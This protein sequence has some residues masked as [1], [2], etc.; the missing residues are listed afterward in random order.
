MYR[1]VRSDYTINAAAIQLWERQSPVLPPE[2][3]NPLHWKLLLQFRK[4]RLKVL[5]VCPVASAI[6]SLH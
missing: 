5:P 3:L 6:A 2:L 4:E 1:L